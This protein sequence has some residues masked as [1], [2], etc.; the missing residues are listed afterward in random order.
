MRI[1]GTKGPTRAK[2]GAYSGTCGTRDAL[3]IRTIGV[4]REGRL[5]LDQAGVINF[6][7]EWGNREEGELAPSLRQLRTAP[8]FKET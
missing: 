3:V 2:K 1:K 5:P 4:G 6:L 8:W 7:W